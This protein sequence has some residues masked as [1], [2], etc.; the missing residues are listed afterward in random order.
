MLAARAIVSATAR[1]IQ[2]PE[3][4]P[5]LV[6]LRELQELFGM[7][8][9]WWRYQIAAGCPARRWGKRLRFDPVDV[10]EWIERRYDGG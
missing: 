7:S 5:R 8:E 2:F 1:I 6:N 4:R 9:R 10:Q 3:R